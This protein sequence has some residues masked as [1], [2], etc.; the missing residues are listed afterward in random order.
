MRC[1]E[2]FSGTGSVGKV[3]KQQGHE[4]IS[5]DLQGADINCDILTW[6]YTAYEPGSFDYIHAS[7]PCDTFS[8][9]RQ[10]N[11]GR[12][13]KALDGERLTMDIIKRDRELIGL[14]L[15]QRTREVLNYFKPKFWTLENPSS[16]DMRHHLTDLPYTDV[17]YCKYGFPYKKMTR[18]WNN[19]DFEGRK[20]RKDCEFIKGKRHLRWDHVSN[21]RD[22]YKMPPDLVADW[23]E[24]IGR[25]NDQ[26]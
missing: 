10:C 24:A 16:S 9:A 23:L 17:T 11:I 12:K 13:L 25:R 21:K 18:I 20:C 1:L 15:L 14:P 6:D 2:L 26:K 22:R 5:L 19:F 8:V 4:V 3:L 7:P